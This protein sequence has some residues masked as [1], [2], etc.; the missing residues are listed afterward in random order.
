MTNRTQPP[1][2]AHHGRRRTILIVAAMLLIAF[3]GILLFINFS[4]RTDLQDA[5]GQ[6][7]QSSLNSKASTLSYF[8]ETRI[9]DIFHLSSESTILSYFQYK[10]LGMSMCYGLLSSINAIKKRI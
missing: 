5:S 9:H 7:L 4:S 6:R 8:L 1:N 2:P 10:N 3:I